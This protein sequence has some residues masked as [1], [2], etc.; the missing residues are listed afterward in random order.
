MKTR[1]VIVALAVSLT[2][3]TAGLG[4]DTVKTTSG[5]VTGEVVKVSR[6]SVD[7]EKNGSV[8]SIPANEV[9]EVFFEDA[10]S[11]LKTARKHATDGRYEDARTAL[12]KV[13]MADV[14]R[15]EIK[16]QVAFCEALCVARLALAGNATIQEAGKK[17]LAFAK[18]YP[19]SY[20]YFQVYELM[21]DLAV[22]NGKHAAAEDFYTQLSKAPWPDFKMR[23]GVAIGR[24]R[25]ARGET[26]DA[27]KAFEA[28]LAIKQEG[29]LANGQ[30]LAANL[31]KARCLAGGGKHDQ[32]I[33]MIEDIVAEAN[34]EQVKLHARAYNAWGTA[35]RA[36]E[37]PNEAALAFLHVH[38]LYH[39]VP[40]AHAEALANLVEVWTQLHQVEQ[41]MEARDTLTQR[42]PNSPWSK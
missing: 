25:L 24:A 28:V 11:A 21:G 5:T 1:S 34:P 14:D 6:L 35:L 29:D 4:F 22:A 10:P 32:A 17:T 18:K 30:R 33:Q 9:L 36:A 39:V 13:K 16:A 27:L 8:K 3:A 42:Y 19:Q 26:A 2:L 37:R 40:D 15:E 12:A 41:A 7:V 20:H 31:G 23:A 38:L